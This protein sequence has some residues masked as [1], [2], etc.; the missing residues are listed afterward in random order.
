MALQCISYQISGHRDVDLRA[1][2]MKI[3]CNLVERRVV[4]GASHWAEP[5]R[6]RRSYDHPSF[7]VCCE[8]CEI[9]FGNNVG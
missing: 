4:N 5:G 7:L 2:N 6:E 1:G 8:D 3:A 9:L